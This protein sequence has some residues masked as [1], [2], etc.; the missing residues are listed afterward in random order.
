M[1]GYWPEL[2]CGRSSGAV[3]VREARRRAPEEAMTKD[4]T[5][6]SGQRNAMMMPAEEE[7]NTTVVTPIKVALPCLFLTYMLLLIYIFNPRRFCAAKKL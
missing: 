6:M 1:A 7:G 3:A 5:Q 4:G 2:R